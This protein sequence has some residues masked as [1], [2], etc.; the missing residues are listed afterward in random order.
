MST[1]LEVK[2]AFRSLIRS[3]VSAFFGT[4]ALGVS[5]GLTT[6]MFTIVYGSLL[7]GLPLPEADQ[8]V[9]LTYGAAEDTA[10][11]PYDVVEAWIEGSAALEH[12]VP[13]FESSVVFSRDGRPAERYLGAYVGGGFFEAAGLPALLGRTLGAEEQHGNGPLAV[14]LSYGLWERRFDLDR[15][16]VG[17]SITLGGEPALVLGVM[18]EGFGFPRKQDFWLPLGKLSAA[19]EAGR[20]PIS[21]LGRLAD[22]TS[23]D[24]AQAELQAIANGRIV[25][26]G[27]ASERARARVEPLQATLA[28]SKGSPLWWMT[29]AVLGVLLIGC[30]NVA[31]LLL[32]R[33]VASRREAA[34]R[35][36]IGARSWTL[37]RPSVVEALMFSSLGGLLGL[38]I[39]QGIVTAYN[40]SG[41]FVDGFWVDVRIHP[42][43]LLAVVV[44]VLGATLITSMLP[45]LYVGR[46]RNAE[47]LKEGGRGV[48]GGR[49]GSPTGWTIAVQM[50]LACSLLFATLMMTQ[51]VRNIEAKDFGEDPET[52]WSTQVILDTARFAEWQNW[53]EVLDGLLVR[54]DELPDVEQAAFTSLLPTEPSRRAAIRTREAIA[55]AD[56]ELPTARRSVVSPGY[57]ST[58]GRPVV[59]GR[60]FDSTDKIGNSPTVVLNRQLAQRLFEDAEAIGRQ[61]QIGGDEYGDLWFT[62]VGVVPNLF[63]NR[64]PWSLSIEESVEPG[65]YLPLAQHPRPG[66][67]LVLR[68]RSRSTGLEAAARSL[69]AE[70]SPDMPALSP[71]ALSERIRTLTEP[72]RWV[73][74]V[75]AVFAVAAIMLTGCGIFASVS[76]LAEQKRPDLAVRIAL[77]ASKRHVAAAVVSRVGAYVALGLAFSVAAGSWISGLLES[78]L[79]GIHG[80]APRDLILVL[81]AVTLVV[82]FAVFLP[83]RDSLR[84]QPADVL[85][86]E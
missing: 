9:G 17:Q 44:T 79:H 26:S 30:F 64:E 49:S 78:Y 10:G 81:T 6:A 18:P 53:L 66:G 15:T 47:W 71:M 84:L 12:V 34:I 51:S 42:V 60:E 73:T 25:P 31:N 54:L 14:V 57:F 16:V 59:Q 38:V 50:M 13:W 37:I 80:L 39:A 4:L 75:F 7:R 40:W 61:V 29:G 24:A 19:V 55:V 27:E 83:I 28:E 35:W 32:A 67:H 69:F 20:I 46:S 62:V 63:L 70:Y 8:L 77:G 82:A 2:R 76:F 48:Q 23:Q 1:R 41:G 3:P 43:V 68:T 58:L 72:H 65:F 85:K 36:S 74:G 11:V 33:Q 5:I 86:G 45:L 52:L 22:G 21:V 56:S